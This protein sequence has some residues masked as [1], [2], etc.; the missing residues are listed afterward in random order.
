MKH[1]PERHQSIAPPPSV[2]ISIAAI[3]VLMAV[4][5]VV[6]SMAK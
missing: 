6:V 1:L 2:I 3:V 4:V 5:W